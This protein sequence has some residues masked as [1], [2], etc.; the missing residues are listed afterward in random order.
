[1]D[2]ALIRL[3]SVV[4][5]LSCALDLTEG[6]PMG[7]AAAA[8]V[9]GMRLAEAIGL[10]DEERS[11]VFYALLLK[12]AGCSANASA[13]AHL[14]GADDQT[15][16]RERRLHEQHQARRLAARLSGGPVLAGVPQG[17]LV[18]LGA[19]GVRRLLELRAERG[20]QVAR[21]LGLGREVALA[22]R[23]VEER[24]DGSGGPEGLT[25]AAIPLAARIAALAQSVEVFNTLNGASY[26]CAMART[27]AGAWFDP[28][29][30]RALSGFEEDDAFWRRLDAAPDPVVLLPALEPSAAVRHV[31]EDAIDGIAETFAGVV[32]A[33]SAY[34]HGHS[35]RVARIAAGAASGLGLAAEDRRDLRR[36]ALLQDLGMLGVSSRI[37]DK[38]GALRADER[39]QL[40]RHPA[41][42]FAVLR[43]IDALRP[44]AHLAAAHHERLD[45]SGYP[46]GLTGEDLPFTARLLAVADVCAARTADRPHR[47]AL[48]V[49]EVLRRLEGEVPR[50]LDPAAFAA[51]E[52]HLLA[53]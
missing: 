47:S 16:K 17:P 3:S 20:A 24:W 28:D 48:P 27:R 15:V 37:L 10:P 5:P 25:A 40:V 42:T 49:D 13:V 31:G 38:P 45:G 23:A 22:V 53:A 1:M 14:Y 9:I 43:R 51:V 4:G 29:L 35:R 30:V 8:C 50:R 39:R 41:R 32:D 36:A 11:T 21:A 34:T 6:H 19:E 26:A 18:Q 2:E 33:K 46:R 7:H 52:A 12:D 44:L